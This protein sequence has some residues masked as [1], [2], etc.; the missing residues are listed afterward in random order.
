M[1]MSRPLSAALVVATVALAPRAAH[2]QQYDLVLANATIVDGSGAARFTG[3]VAI[4]G[5]KIARVAREAIP[6]A[7][8]KR[9]IDVKGRVVAPGFIDV[10]AH[11]E[12]L[13]QMPDAESAIRQGITLSL[14]G[15]DGGGPWPFGAYLDSAGK[16]KLG[17]NVAYLVGHNTI[18]REVMGT[19]NRAPTAAELDKMK[20]MVA[21]AMREG[22]FG[23]STGLRYVPGYYS[24]TPEVIELAKVAAASR[25][26][27]TSHLREEGLG[28]IEGVAEAIEI[29][30]QARIPI[31]LTHHKAIG[32][33]MWGKST[34]TLA[35]VDSA[36]RAGLDVMIDQYP[37]T[38]SSTGFSVLVPPWALEGGTAEFKK[39]V[40]NPELR[41]AIEA[42]IK[43][44]L[45]NDRGGGDLK[46][47]QFASVGWDRSLEGKTL[48]DWAVQ[49][50]LPPTAEGAVPLVIEGVLKGSPS[51]VF[52]VI[53]ERDVRRIMAHPQTMIASDGRLDRPGPSVP[54]PR[55]YGTFPRV[56]GEYVRVQKVLTLESAVHKMSGLPAKRLGLSD[57]GCVRDGCAADLVVFDPATVSDKGT[58]TQPHQYPVGI[59][60]V[61]VAGEAVFAD[62]KMTGAR[63]GRVIRR[64]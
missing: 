23:L 53:D 52:H 43:D 27:Y 26:I 22:A 33:K 20:Q 46:R 7:Q 64:Q 16:S 47:V 3:A 34:V 29:G 13:L 9:V 10:H 31:V 6:A 28:L 38:A 30:R 57:R 45:L 58:F 12:P 62:G 50:K 18:R 24:K 42:G 21:T 1:N 32:Q 15:P 14:G 48:Y 2:S 59:D 44:L 51:M 41:N 49:R 36:R 60:Y 37:Y 11:I 25:G 35:M 56:L 39:R 5:G 61:L 4:T 55:N 17:M 8:A 19:A 40:E 54:H 63:P